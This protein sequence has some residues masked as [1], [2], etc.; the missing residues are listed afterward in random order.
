MLDERDR[1]S[2]V[3]FHADRGFGSIAR[4]GLPDLFFHASRLRDPI[5][6]ANI[7][8][9]TIVEYGTEQAVCGP[10]ATDVVI[11]RS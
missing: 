3:L 11:V 5:D 7:A 10:T 1:G 6:K 9:G 4:A 8:R 2:V